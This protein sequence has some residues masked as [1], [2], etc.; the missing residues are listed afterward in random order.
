MMHEI[1][2]QSFDN[3]FIQTSSIND[4][5]LIFLFHENRLLLI[6]HGDDFKIPQKKQLPS[7]AD[8]T[9]HTFLFKL[10]NVPCFLIWDCPQIEDPQCI[11]REIHFFR[12]ISQPEIQWAGAVASHL[13]NWYS[14][15]KFCGVCGSKT[16]E[17]GDERALI[18]P[19]CHTTVF[20]KISPAIIVAIV[21]KDQ[22]LLAHNTN[23]RANWYSLI[24]G[25]ADIGESLEEAVIRESKEEVGLDVFNI[26]YYKSQPWPFSGSMMIGF[27]ADA[28]SAQPVCVDKKEIEGA[29]WFS[30]G[31][32]PN[33]PE[34]HSIAGELIEKFENNEL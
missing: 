25:Y 11:Y 14:H 33:H 13:L 7:S 26:R 30:R 2:P 16:V 34:N 6:P 31:N 21:C 24:A 20:P 5:D 17:K 12:R 8:L 27:F 15:N 9:R 19:A 32:L 22:I 23:F 3:Q 28:D 29:A 18:C 10:N 4:D 1:H